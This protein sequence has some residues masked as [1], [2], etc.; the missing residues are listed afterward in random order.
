MINESIQVILKIK[1]NANTDIESFPQFKVLDKTTVS[2]DNKLFKFDC[3]SN[4]PGLEDLFVSNLKPICDKYLAGT[5]IA[6]IAY[7]QKNTGKTYTLFGTKKEPGLIQKSYEYIKTQSPTT[8]IKSSYIEIHQDQVYDLLASSTKSRTGKEENLH[9][10]YINSISHLQQILQ[11]TPK[12]SGVERPHRVF[13]IMIEK[14]NGLRFQFVDLSG[15]E[16]MKSN[17]TSNE[18]IKENIET[19]KSLSS[20]EQAILS[21]TENSKCI[22]FI[23]SQISLFFKDSLLKSKIL[24]IATVSPLKNRFL[25]TLATIKFI[26]KVRKLSLCDFDEEKIVNIEYLQQEIM[27]LKRELHVRSQSQNDL[28][29]IVQE[30]QNCEKN[31]KKLRE[32]LILLETENKIL[33]K[34]VIEFNKI[35]TSDWLLSSDSDENE[36]TC[37]LKKERKNLEVLHENLKKNIELNRITS[38]DAIISEKE[39]KIKEL[40]GIQNTTQIQELSTEIQILKKKCTNYQE[41]SVLLSKQNS[42]L[43]S[44]LSR[45]KEICYDYIAE[46]S[47]LS[48]TDSSKCEINKIIEE[49]D[50]KVKNLEENLKIT[51][52]NLHIIKEKY[53]KDTNKYKKSIEKLKNELSITRLENIKE[54]SQAMKV[55]EDLKDKKIKLLTI[56]SDLKENP[57]KNKMQELKEINKMLIENIKIKGQQIS[58]LKDQFQGLLNNQGS[59]PDLIAKLGRKTFKLKN[60]QA[61]ISKL[62]SYIFKLPQFRNKLDKMTVSDCIIE[63]FSELNSRDPTKHSIE[64]LERLSFSNL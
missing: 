31:I 7:G 33:K 53:I 20:I 13:T 2:L 51:E 1:N 54:N 36:E 47:S 5:P 43:L 23:E 57:D 64:K 3:I 22:K 52:E 38:A 56:I 46:F 25:D 61:E 48:S 9:Y 21:L 15:G 30:H 42:D 17:N 16:G 26:K 59:I 62:K 58:D 44:E 41:L 49:K 18:K 29:E 24:L 45:S 32:N 50:F 60:L 10:E 40:S 37:S 27:N 19:K 6:L 63:F 12:K 4:G 34:E 28:L 14:F 55:L 11:S 39:D 8:P 35:D